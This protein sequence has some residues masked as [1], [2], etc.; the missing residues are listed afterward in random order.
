MKEWQRIHS[1]P[2]RGSNKNAIK[3][4]WRDQFLAGGWANP[5]FSK[6]T[7]A[8]RCKKDEEQGR[9][10]SWKEHCDALGTE[11]ATALAED[12]VLESKPW[13]GTD[14]KRKLKLWRRVFE[15]DTVA[16]KHKEGQKLDDSVGHVTGEAAA[17]WQQNASSF[18][19]GGIGSSNSSVG[20]RAK[21]SKPNDPDDDNK[22]D[23]MGPTTACLVALRKAITALDAKATSA[24]GLAS[25]TQ[26]NKYCAA[27]VDE[28]GKLA[29]RAE[30]RPATKKRTPNF[31]K[32]NPPKSG[33]QK[34][35]SY[36]CH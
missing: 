9:W 23:P 22:D 12:G 20:K 17:M 11:V 24:R 3:A 32:A 21:D 28:I 6:Y 25:Q 31:H 29:K 4:E 30:K 26:N 13:P 27:L 1:L 34:I 18:A 33:A 2:G 8:E 19:H 16:N 14:P 15:T 5:F 7:I 36:T 35:I 10:L